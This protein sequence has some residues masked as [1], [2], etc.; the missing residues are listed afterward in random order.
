MKV[1]DV[2]NIIDA[3]IDEN[4]SADTFNDL[5]LQYRDADDEKRNSSFAAVGIYED[6]QLSA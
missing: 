6:Q 3:V 4:N 1:K 2:V 5:Y